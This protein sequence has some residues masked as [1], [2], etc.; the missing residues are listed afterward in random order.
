M[1]TIHY[2]RTGRKLR[3]TG[4]ILDKGESGMVKVKP[5]RDSWGS[6]WL[7]AAE[8]EAGR[9]KAPQTPRKTAKDKPK[10]VK[11]PKPAPVPKWKQLV[12]RVRANHDREMLCFGIADDDLQM[13]LADELE[14]AHALLEQSL[15]KSKP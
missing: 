15:F 3:S 5:S 6:V 8:I 9:G 13:Q 7:T 14:A 4:T 1:A 10:R 11:K 2:L 12:E